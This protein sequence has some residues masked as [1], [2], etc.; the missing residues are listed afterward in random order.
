MKV[1]RLEMP[2]GVSYVFTEKE[3]KDEF[4]AKG[5]G[6]FIFSSQVIFEELSVTVKQLEKARKLRNNKEYC[7]DFED[8][9]G[10]QPSVYN[11]L[12][13]HLFN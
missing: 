9:Y 4:T 10:F 8:E 7:L 13:R 5:T 6:E 3:L 2:N 12:I 1:F 11:I